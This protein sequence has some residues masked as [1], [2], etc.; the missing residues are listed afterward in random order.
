MSLPTNGFGAELAR[1]DSL[2]TGP[3]FPAV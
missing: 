3:A 1:I 2:W